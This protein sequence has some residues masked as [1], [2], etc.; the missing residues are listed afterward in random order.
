MDAAGLTEKLQ[1]KLKELDHRIEI[2][3]QQQVDNFMRDAIELLSDTP[4]E[5]YTQ[6]KDNISLCLGEFPAVA[7]VLQGHLVAA[8]ALRLVPPEAKT[9]GMGKG[10]G[11][12]TSR[13]LSPTP[14]QAPSNS[15]QGEECDD[16]RGHTRS[17][18][19]REDELQ[20]LFTPSYLPLLEGNVQS[21]PKRP[22][23]PPAGRPGTGRRVVDKASSS[24]AKPDLGSGGA[25]TPRSALR[26]GSSS[27]KPPHSPQRRVRFEVSGTEFSPT[28][29]PSGSTTELGAKVGGDGGVV[30][31]SDIWGDDDEPVPKKISSTDKL[32]ALAKLNPDPDKPWPPYHVDD[33]ESCSAHGDSPVS[34]HGMPA[35]P[36]CSVDTS[37]S[38]H[39][40]SP[41]QGDEDYSED[42]F[43]SMAKPKSFTNK[44]PVGISAKGCSVVKEDKGATLST[45]VEEPRSAVLAQGL[46]S[47][48][49]LVEDDDD[50][51]MFD[52]DDGTARE[53]TC[54]AAVEEE[55]DGED[56]EEESPAEPLQTSS[57]S[58]AMSI[59]RPE[60]KT[61][62]VARA[63]TSSS[64]QLAKAATAPVVGS[65]KG[66]PIV[67]PVVLDPAVQREAECLPA[68][69][70]FV[71]GLDGRSGMD[72]ADP[73]SFHASISKATGFSGTPRSFSERLMIEE[74]EERRQEQD[75]EKEKG[76][77]KEDKDKESRH[78][79]SW[80]VY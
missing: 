75:A 22:T 31:A 4:D 73:S 70:M 17:S 66:K 42:E 13:L 25:M 55:G 34:T 15:R 54:E 3:R 78:I 18:H 12:M 53:K 69:G 46:G 61:T 60:P 30:S 39:Q 8:D 37:S 72:E 11:K 23:T 56:A 43:L 71:G 48:T 50:I 10:K 80:D 21:T 6:V 77:D 14:P 28:A 68:M 49:R 16:A 27:S 74:L 2:Y 1:T 7:S 36:S 47:D 38:T 79:K 20:G 51:F 64:S 19:D 29:S 9:E 67:M 40:H 62:G 52:D 33:V 44:K 58:Q 41:K 65:Y 5:L 26:R 24:S 32:R 35:S 63:W 57:A 76:K 59:S 45:A